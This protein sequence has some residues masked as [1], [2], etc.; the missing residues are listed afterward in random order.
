MSL[1][2]TPAV[3]VKTA[4]TN[5]CEQPFEFQKRLVLTATKDIGQYP[6]RVMIQC[7]PQPPWLF[8]AADKGPPLVQ[9]DLSYLVN[10]HCGL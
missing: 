1:V 5:R 7:L 9:F 10:A 8:L 3:G 2:G 6:A 4:N